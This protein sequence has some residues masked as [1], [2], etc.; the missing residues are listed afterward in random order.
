M[1][2]AMRA[3]G[4]LRSPILYEP[5]KFWGCKPR[6]I[7]HNPEPYY[8]PIVVNDVYLYDL[9]PQGNDK[10]FLVP[11]RYIDTCFAER[12]DPGLPYAPHAIRKL[13]ATE[14]IDHELIV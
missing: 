8:P 4:F 5:Y 7:T 14:K 3:G 13:F 9:D 1:Q 11:V 10:L 12:E 6:L 2:R